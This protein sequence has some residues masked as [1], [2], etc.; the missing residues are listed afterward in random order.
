MVAEIF[1]YVGAIL[2]VIGGAFGLIAAIGMLRFPDLYTRMHAASKAGIVSAGF[3]FAAI[4]FVSFDGSV[5]L[6]ALMGVFFL[7]LTTPVS[8]HLLARVAYFSGVRPVED[9]RP[10][11]MENEG[12]VD[13]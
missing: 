5:A 6:R 7:M 11:E 13:R 4:G 8:A 2:V 1:Y 10:N 3:I 9:T 12:P